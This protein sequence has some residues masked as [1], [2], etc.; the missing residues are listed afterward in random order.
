MAPIRDR[1]R[2]RRTANR[3][4]SKRQHYTRSWLRDHCSHGEQ[5]L[6]PVALCSAW[7]PIFPRADANGTPVS[8]ALY[9]RKSK[10]CSNSSLR[11]LTGSHH[12]PLLPLLLEIHL[13][14]RGG[15]NKN[16][17]LRCGG[18]KHPMHQGRESPLVVRPGSLKRPGWKTYRLCLTLAHL[19]VLPHQ[20][21]NE[22]V[23]FEHLPLPVGLP[24]V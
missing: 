15:S 21:V 7:M 2:P 18:P 24:C 19:G 22:Q 11:I 9:L 8:S 13:L 6:G 3:I 10:S 14:G 17:L 4:L 1:H 16:F 23:I 12:D 20:A 5:P